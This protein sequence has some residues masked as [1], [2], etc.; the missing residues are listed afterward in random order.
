MMLFVLLAL[1]LYYVDR[2]V[3]M[4]A[5]AGLLVGLLTLCK[6]NAGIFGALAVGLT[7]LLRAR[8]GTLRNILLAG[9]AV[10][11]TAMPA[12]L[13]HSSHGTWVQQWLFMATATIA[14]S[15]M[16]ALKQRSTPTPTSL[17]NCIAAATA[18]LAGVVLVVTP[19]LIGGHSLKAMVR[20]LIFRVSRGGTYFEMPAGFDL[21]S[22]VSGVAAVL[23]AA[24][25][26]L[27]IGGRV[28]TGVIFAMRL[29]LGVIA[30]LCGLSDLGRVFFI[31]LSPWVWLVGVGKLGE[32]HHADSRI[33]ICLLAAIQTLWAF[34][35]APH[36]HFASILLIVSAVICMGDSL[37]GL[38]DRIGIRSLSANRHG[39]TAAAICLL[40]LAGH[41]YKLQ[42][43][44]SRY[45]SMV[46]LDLPGAHAVRVLPAQYRLYHEAVQQIHQSCNGFITM[47]ALNS[48]YFW[49]RQD[50]PTAINLT[51]WI[52]VLDDVEQQ[53]MTDDFARVTRPCVVQCPAV[54]KLWLQGRPL[55]RRPLVRW[56]EEHFQ[57]AASFEGCHLLT[58]K[59]P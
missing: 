4:A 25:Y 32:G 40:V 55:P 29:A 22:I 37:P 36:I 27:G 41:L 54:M 12:V 23:V 9:L 16:C 19:L 33:G 11:T 31:Y 8:P 5:I 24:A 26:C 50:S 59:Q 49:S 42:T 51:A 52:G 10:A 20:M 2:G 15:L 13:M 58:W 43:A 3:A 21:L 45:A 38:Y 44:R 18:C 53:Q 39:F 1:T 48:L 57:P 47:P 46:P 34:P 28:V 30:I 14:G 6:V 17:R 35:M 7:L 56:I